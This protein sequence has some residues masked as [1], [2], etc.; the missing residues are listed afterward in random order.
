MQHLY[1]QTNLQLM[2]HYI[3]IST[4]AKAFEFL[5]C[6]SYFGLIDKLTNRSMS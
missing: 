1:I 4:S 6:I 5:A 2:L 3:F